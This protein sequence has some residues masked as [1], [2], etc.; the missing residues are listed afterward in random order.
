MRAAFTVILVIVAIGDIF[1]S[2]QHSN[3]I[4]VRDIESPTSQYG[5]PYD[6]HGGIVYMS[7]PERNIMYAYYGLGIVLV[8]AGATLARIDSK[9]KKR[10]GA[11]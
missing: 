8:I 3:R 11:A 4:T 1:F 10:R 2:Y 5:I 7:P 6:T 9:N